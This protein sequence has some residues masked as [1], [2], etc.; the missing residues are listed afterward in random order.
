MR[1]VFMLILMI[2][3]LLLCLPIE[4]MPLEIEQ[5]FKDF[6]DSDSMNAFIGPPKMCSSTGWSIYQ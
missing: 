1:T 2:N 3:L 6:P 4:V 5:D